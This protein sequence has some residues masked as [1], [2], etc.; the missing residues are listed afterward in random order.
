MAMMELGTDRAT[1]FL[2]CLMNPEPPEFHRNELELKE[3]GIIYLL[4]DR[5]TVTFCGPLISHIS[6]LGS[7]SESGCFVGQP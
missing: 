6:S 7:R 2:A 4:Q 1:D 5:S 3:S